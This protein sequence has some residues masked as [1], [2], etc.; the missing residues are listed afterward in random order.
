MTY[1]GTLDLQFIPAK[2][3]NLLSTIKA[4][5]NIQLMCQ[6]KRYQYENL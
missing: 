4:A 6:G 2:A 1:Y 3:K 5:V